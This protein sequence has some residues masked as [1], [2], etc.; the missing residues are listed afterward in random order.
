MNS[1]KYAIEYTSEFAT[2]TQ[3]AR[4]WQSGQLHEAVNLAT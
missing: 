2:L 4:R 1:S 3:S